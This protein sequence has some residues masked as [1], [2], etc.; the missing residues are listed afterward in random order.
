MAAKENRPTCPF[1]ELEL[2]PLR[3]AWR[4]VSLPPIDKPR[5]GYERTRTWCCPRCKFEDVETKILKDRPRDGGLD[6]GGF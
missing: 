6:G 4:S 5:T 3:T 1:C 2:E